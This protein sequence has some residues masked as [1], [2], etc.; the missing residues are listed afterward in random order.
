MRRN[1]VISTWW[2]IYSFLWSSVPNL[3]IKCPSLAFASFGELSKWSFSPLNFSIYSSYLFEI[4]DIKKKTSGKHLFTVTI[5]TY[6]PPAR[7]SVN[8]SCDW[9]F[10]TAVWVIGG[11]GQIWEPLVYHAIF[12]NGKFNNL[13]IDIIILCFNIQHSLAIRQVVRCF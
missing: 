1:R 4:A 3:K 7:Q 9:A 2:N 10:F 11:Y 8:L 13:S 6:F 12:K 5:K